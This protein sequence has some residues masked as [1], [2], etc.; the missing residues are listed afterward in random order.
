MYVLFFVLHI[1]KNLQVYNLQLVYNVT[2]NLEF[3]QIEC[4]IH[5]FTKIHPKIECDIHINLIHPANGLYEC[6][7]P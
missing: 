6:M 5:V 2:C 4:D 3:A 7:S 1:T